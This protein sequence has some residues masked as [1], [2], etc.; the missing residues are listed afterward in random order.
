MNSWY[1]VAAPAG[2]TMEIVQR[3]NSELNRGLHEPAHAQRL[4]AFGMNS[5]QTTPAEFESFLRR[6]LA[7]W[8][9]VIREVGVRAQAACDDA[10]E[11]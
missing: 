5:M 8:G 9:K 10:C 7:K 6:E 3:L 2:T 1:G 4:K 11:V